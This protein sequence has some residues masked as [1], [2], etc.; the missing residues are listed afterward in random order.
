MAE[1]DFREIDDPVIA[2]LRAADPEM[3]GSLLALH[4]ERIRR[5]IGFL[6]RSYEPHRSVDSRV[7]S[8]MATILVSLSARIKNGRPLKNEDQLTLMA[9][10]YQMA[11]YVVQEKKRTVAKNRERFAPLDEK[12]IADPT[13]VS[14]DDVLDGER[15]W[16]MLRAELSPR[17]F[18]MLEL[19]YRQ[20]MTYYD[21]STAVDGSGKPMS[22]GAIRNR[23]KRAISRLR[24]QFSSQKGAAK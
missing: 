22:P 24:A 7:H 8:V 20:D 2:D 15:M 3:I 17:D 11:R 9:V 23:L 6:V 4:I 19:R 16:E 13:N 12:R 21:I 10:L 14:A 18:K 5:R 1:N